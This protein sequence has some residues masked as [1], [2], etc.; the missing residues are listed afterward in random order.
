[1]KQTKTIEQIIFLGLVFII[2]AWAAYSAL[3]FPTQAQTFPWFVALG[4]MGITVA[5]LIS[6]LITQRQAEKADD[7]GNSISPK[8][9][10]ILPYLAWLL[11][12]YGAIYVL[13][14]VFASGIFVLLFLLIPGKM[15]WYWAVIAAVLVIVFLI[16]MEDVMNL[17]W[18]RSVIDPI[19]MVGLH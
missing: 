7:S 19:A 2:F 17:R 4:A 13:G 11:A 6:F 1:M 12:Y 10:G 8:I 16:S 15:K 18:P 3:E 9:G 14:M 5:E